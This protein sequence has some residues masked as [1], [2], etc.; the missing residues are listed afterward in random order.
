ML[1]V[2]LLAGV[3]AACSDPAPEP[4]FEEAG[5]VLIPNL[6]PSWTARFAMDDT[7]PE[8][9][10]FVAD[11]PHGHLAEVTVLVTPTAIAVLRTNGF[12]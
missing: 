12:A 3:L 9:A 7:E 2:L 11:A 4:A 1:P 6:R 8:S 5:E 10:M